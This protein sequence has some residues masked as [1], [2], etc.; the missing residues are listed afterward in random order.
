LL[1]VE[2]D[3]DDALL[4]VREL[5]R[6]GYEPSWERVD[7]ATALVSAIE[8]EPW[9]VITCDWVM[10]QFSAPVALA[11]LR[12]HRVDAPIIIVTGEVGEEV[13]VTGMKAGA[14]PCGQLPPALTDRSR[15]ARTGEAAADPQ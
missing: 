7:T 10:P 15:S 3:E 8:R 4:V 6:G 9:D 5:E 12:E 11:L 14:L 13:A 2:D 1:L